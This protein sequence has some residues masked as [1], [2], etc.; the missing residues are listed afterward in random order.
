[1]EKVFNEWW[2]KNFPAENFGSLQGAF[3]EAM[4]TDI[5]LKAFKEGMRIGYDTNYD[6]KLRGEVIDFIILNLK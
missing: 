4:K 2:E 1:M 6:S 3:R 5:A